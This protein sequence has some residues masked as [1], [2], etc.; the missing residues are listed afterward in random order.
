[1]DGWHFLFIYNPPIHNYLPYIMLS[2]DQNFMVVVILMALLSWYDQSKP[3]PQ[4]KTRRGG[5]KLYKKLNL[6]EYSECRPNNILCSFIPCFP[7]SFHSMSRLISLCILLWFH[8]SFSEFTLFRLFWRS[9]LVYSPCLF[10]LPDPSPAI[11]PA[12]KETQVARRFSLTSSLA[13]SSASSFA[14]RRTK[15]TW[16]A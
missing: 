13:S 12:P 6:M 5:R 4:K 8:H 9:F 1:M 2:P 14:T 7:F 10:S 15:G 16:L 3:H 11:E